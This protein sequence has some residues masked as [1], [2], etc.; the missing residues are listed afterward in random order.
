[1]LNGRRRQAVSPREGENGRDD[2][3]EMMA[4][5]RWRLTVRCVRRMSN[6]A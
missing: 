4:V 5:H 2:A 3:E 1:M 6:A